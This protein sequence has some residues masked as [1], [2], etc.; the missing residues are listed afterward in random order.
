MLCAANDFGV[1]Y[2]AGNTESYQRRRMGVDDSGYFRL[3]S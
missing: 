3:A 2:N 1:G